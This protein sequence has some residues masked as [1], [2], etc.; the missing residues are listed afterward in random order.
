MTSYGGATSKLRSPALGSY[1]IPG[2]ARTSAIGAS[3][4]LNVPQIRHSRDLAESLQNI[5]LHA[6][7]HGEDHHRAA[8]RAVATHLHA[9]DVDVVLAEDGA[10]TPHQARPVLMPADQ[11]A[12]GGNKVDPKRVDA[13]CARL[14]HDHRARELVTIDAQSHHAGIA[15]TRRAAPLDQPDAAT[16]SDQARVDLVDAVFG[17]RLEYPFDG[18]CD[19]EVD[20]VLGELAVEIELDRADPAAEELRVQRRQAF[21]EGCER[22]QVS[23]LFGWQCGCVDG[24]TGQVAG[25]DRRHFL[26]RVE[27]DRPLRFGP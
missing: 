16:R 15:P 1:R 20:V 23:E 4:E 18:R 3:L 12:A 25:Q 19:D 22:A 27:P 5:S 21:G 24:I 7:V 2:S 11:E 8:T 6:I 14:A 26:G 9:C 17:E 10:H 13:D